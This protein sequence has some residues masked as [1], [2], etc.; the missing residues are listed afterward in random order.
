MPIKK[1]PQ[2][3]MK[4]NFL[5]DQLLELILS[6]D[7][8]ILHEKRRDFDKSDNYYH[9]AI[10]IIG[11]THTSSAASEQFQN[12]LNLGGNSLYKMKLDWPQFVKFFSDPRNKPTMDIEPK[13]CEDF[14]RYWR[15]HY[16]QQ[17]ENF[18]KTQYKGSKVLRAKNLNEISSYWQKI[19]I[20]L[21][22]AESSA[23]LTTHDHS[24]DVL[25]PVSYQSQ[26]Q[27]IE[28]SK[29]KDPVVALALAREIEG[30]N[31]R[32]KLVLEVN[33]ILAV[34]KQ[35]GMTEDQIQHQVGSRL[36]YGKDKYPMLRLPSKR[37][38]FG[39]K[40]MPEVMKQTSVDELE[41]TTHQSYIDDLYSISPNH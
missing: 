40:A 24:E 21:K 15:A 5:K 39:L 25:G 4:G 27:N 29:Q 26:H 35:R 37:L 32:E 36:I 28:L 31:E 19:S 17:W 18:R 7:E 1:I 10:V 6:I 16:F 34:C 33:T 2:R 38:Q 8:A 23:T 12:V 14:A 3:T 30:R 11:L 20:I 9:K 13:K 41:L 22:Y